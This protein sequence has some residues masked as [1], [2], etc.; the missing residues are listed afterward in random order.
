MDELKERV[1][2]M[3]ETLS[4]EQLEMVVRYADSLNG[5]AGQAFENE[6]VVL[7]DDGEEAAA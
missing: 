5:R 4:F 2:K 6:L 1:T 7:L 3:L